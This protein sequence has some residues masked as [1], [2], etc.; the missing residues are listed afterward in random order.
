ML[1]NTHL[2]REIYEQ[3]AAIQRFLQNE[4]GQ[5]ENL[6]QALQKHEIDHVVIAA[7][8]TSDNVARY[9]KYAWGAKNGLQVAL[10]TPSLFSVYEQPVSF[11]K[12]SLVLGI[13]Q[14]GQS[15]DIVGVVAEA[16][17]Q[18]RLTAA[19]TNNPSS[20]LAQ[21]A[22][23]VIQLHA[24]E[25]KAV[26][27]TKTY[28]SSLM[29]VSA[30][31]AAIAGNEARWDELQSVPEAMEQTLTMYD[32]V[33]SVAPRF[34]YMRFCVV[35]GRGYNYATAFELALKMKE[36]TYSIVEPYSSADFLH[37]PFALIEQGF[38]VI[39]IAP[40]GAIAPT[41]MEFVERLVEASAEPMI[42]SDVDTLLA[43]A[44]VPLRLPSSV[45]EWLS[46]FTTMIPG[47]LLALCLA[48]ERGFDVDAPRL[49][50][51]VTRTV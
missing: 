26:A 34:R 41:M 50:N 44:T 33:A 23:F 48:N 8:G 14:S 3:P 13:S 43:K 32:A 9:A 7:R 4:R 6:A 39:V 5:V 27:A 11:G 29:A 24:G 17:K 37:G 42:I 36:L 20:P 18:G 22:D 10:A 38:P 2:Y 40:Q 47:Q 19:I 16:K 31:S 25:E 21:Q 30:L 1:Q 35:I 45:A 51:K 28:T 15:P 49:L 12:Q 46:P